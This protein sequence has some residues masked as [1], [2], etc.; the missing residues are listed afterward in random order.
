MFGVTPRTICLRKA[1]AERKALQALSRAC[2]MKLD[3][4]LIEMYRLV[5][6]V[7]RK[8]VVL[9][10]LRRCPRKSLMRTTRAFVG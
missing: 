3:I 4:V 7:F 9:V 6:H 10:F 8:V 5:D 2:C 1:L